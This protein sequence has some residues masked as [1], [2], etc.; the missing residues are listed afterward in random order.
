MRQLILHMSVSLDG[1]VAHGDGNI[2]WLTPSD[3][4]D[5][6]ARRHRANLEML[7]E[8]GLIAMGRERQVN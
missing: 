7:R 2:D 6:G 5:H 4:V 3:G 8:C 1:Y